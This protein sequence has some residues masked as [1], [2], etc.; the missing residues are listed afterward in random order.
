MNGFENAMFELGDFIGNADAQRGDLT[1]TLTFNEPA[2]RNHF[3]AAIKQ[4]F[5][6][7]TLYPTEILGRGDEFQFNGI[8]VKVPGRAIIDFQS[9]RWDRLA[10]TKRE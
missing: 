9:A 8:K 3:L 4:A 2:D 6:A 7:H 5:H 10:G 1:I